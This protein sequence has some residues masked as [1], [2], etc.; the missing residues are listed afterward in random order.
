MEL[1]IEQF[2]QRGKAVKDVLITESPTPIEK[3]NDSEIQLLL[4]Y[5][6]TGGNCTLNLSLIA[7][8]SCQ[9]FPSR[10]HEIKHSFRS[11]MLIDSMQLLHGFSDN[12]NSRVISAEVNTE[13]ALWLPYISSIFKHCHLVGRGLL[14]W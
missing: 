5:F 1:S 7:F 8:P 13:T 14:W 4:K 6:P 12:G 2:V 11:G 9:L 3:L 10:V